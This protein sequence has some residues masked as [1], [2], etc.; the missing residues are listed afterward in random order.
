M[1]SPDTPPRHIAVV[2][3]GNGRW[4]AAR[5]LP[6]A[7]G[8]ARGIDAAKRLVRGVAA[9]EIPW[10]TLFC[11]SAENWSRPTPEVDALMELLRRGLY[12]ETPELLRSGVRLHTI[13]DADKLP[14]DMRVLIES[15]AAR[16]HEA[17]RGGARLNLTLA[18]NYGGQQ[19][20]LQAARRWAAS[21]A[22][23]EGDADADDL[24]AARFESLLQ[25]SHMP[26]PDLLIRTGGEQRLSNF[27]LWPLAYTEIVFSDCLWP[28]FGEAELESALDEYARRERRFGGLGDGGV[29]L[30]EA[31]HA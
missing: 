31:G 19:D 29:S 24:D 25:T 15:A 30:S 13:G 5:A 12:A 20:I 16:S 1:T 18:L 21:V 8:H 2:M 11:F 26:P 7:T 10:L 3:D 9:R 22:A 6:R 27:L 4:A 17:T 14:R 23:G 28:D